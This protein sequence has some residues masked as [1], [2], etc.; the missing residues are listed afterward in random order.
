MKGDFSHE[1]F[2]RFIKQSADNFRMKAPD[3]VWQNL[4]AKMHNRRRRVIYGIASIFLATAFAGYLMITDWNATEP[5]TTNAS[6]AP[7]SAASTTTNSTNQPNLT[8]P[9]EDFTSNVNDLI[10]RNE[11]AVDGQMTNVVNPITNINS[12]NR[13]N[14]FEEQLPSEKDNGGVTTT[15][16]DSYDEF[17]QQ[18][19]REDLQSDKTLNTITAD[20][21]PFTIESVLNSYKGKNRK[22]IEKQF[23]FSPTI[24]YRK[25]AEN[26]SYLRNLPAGTAPGTAAPFYS[27]INNM[28]THKPDMGFELG[29]ALKYPLTEKLKLRGGFQFN[30]NRYDVKAFS[31]PLAVATIRL[32]NATR[33]D[34]V[35]VI[36]GYSNV[37]GYK[38][39]WLQNFSMQ[40][41]VPL[42]AE[43]ILKGN[44]KMQLGVATTVQPT[45]VLGD[46][47]Y[48][49]TTDYKNYTE[50]PWLL[51]RWNVNT[52][53]ETFVSYNTG[54]TK[55]QVGPQV[56][57][58]LLSS[59][60]TKYPVKENLF[61]FGLKLG[62]SVNK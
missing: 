16:V 40:L 62:V 56:R 61:D 2:E 58:Q 8:L 55:W 13:E 7:E 48:L 49:I 47:T 10:A 21:F 54:K 51:R 18:P 28:V 27:N 59:F 43:V 36:S 1:N 46:R 45:Y 15:I 19:L 37:N 26:K 29:Y 57:Y 22:R 4:S 31:S 39:N 3:R 6:K 12:V 42:G 33:V 50:Q 11:P 44:D 34:S 14:N 20:R 25:L 5:L 38:S 41:S 53:F 60:I 30:V 24:S 32:N 52:A 35:S 17:D 23:Y 9:V